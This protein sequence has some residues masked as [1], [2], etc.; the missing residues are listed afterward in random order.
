MP[1][2]P[3]TQTNSP[4]YGL[5]LL[6]QKKYTEAEPILRECLELREKLL[7]EKQANLWQVANAKSMLGEALLAGKK[8]A[9]AT[10]LLL[11]GYEG[12]RQDENAIPEVVWKVR[13]AE[14]IQR[15]IDLARARNKP[16]DV[17]K[18]QAE[19]IGLKSKRE[20]REEREELTVAAME[21][22]RRGHLKE[23]SERFVEVI[24]LAPDEL[25][26][27]FNLGCLLAY[28]QDVDRYRKHCKAMW[29][30]F[31][32]SD[33]LEIAERT[34]ETCLLLPE[35]GDAEKLLA[36]ANR[37]LAMAEG[38]R[39]RQ[40]WFSLLK[41]L[42]LYRNGAFGD[43]V[44]L[45]QKCQDLSP[46]P[47]PPRA[48]MADLLS[49]MAYQRLGETKKARLKLDLA[50]QRIDADLPP[51]SESRPMQYA[52]PSDW[53]I[54]QTL[55]RE[56]ESLIA[57]KKGVATAKNKPDD[58]KKWQTEHVGS[59]ARTQR[60]A[61]L[62][63]D[64]LG[65]KKYTEAEPILR[66]CLELREKLLE[67]KQASL[68]QV[69]NEKSMLGEALL[70]QNKPA[71]AEPL[72]VAGYEGL[73]QDD[74]PGVGVAS[75]ERM[76][77]AIERLIDVARARNKPDDVKKWQAQRMG[78]ETKRELVD[79]AIELARRG[80]LKEASEGFAKV[81]QL[82][83]EGHWAW[84]NQACLL[85]YQNDVEAYRKHCLAMWD[86]FEKVDEPT[87]AERTG[88]TCLLLP[89]GGDAKQLLAAA[90][91]WLAKAENEREPQQLVLNHMKA[92]ALYRN[93]AFS[94]CL[95]VAQK[96]R[97]LGGGGTPP[98][99]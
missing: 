93:G 13:V 39:D 40:S 16:D 23:A 86:K 63:L 27:W 14:A 62:G 25:W 9:E 28:Q 76:T 41:A 31:G 98:S 37:G 57:G 79:A 73:K 35:G 42:A 51:V 46:D 64:L 50:L 66:E 69:A 44:Q 82:S 22:G 36:K 47:Y 84:F 53:L 72:L 24:Q 2:H 6:G 38:N 67:E 90:N 4:A 97:D 48:A 60:L 18:W 81:I 61:A 54:C 55:R 91:R 96:C 59:S 58:V 19:L 5:N 10:S 89:E 56:A 1:S 78:L 68:W 71:E 29:E 43:C 74:G 77:E 34:G 70:R 85:A 75:D 52:G 65:Q 49:A 45:A 87:V 12:L 11:A 3:P 30:R 26:A 83:P 94:D 8:P 15:L 88:K 99:K 7:E 21:L 32:N 92:L 95:Q 20:L 17:K 33:S 80:H